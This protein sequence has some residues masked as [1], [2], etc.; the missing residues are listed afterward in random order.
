MATFASFFVAFGS[1][2]ATPPGLLD[3]DH[4]AVR[5]VMAVQQEVTADWMRRPEVLGTAIG[6]NATGAAALVVYVDRDADAAADVARSFPAN[7]RSIGVRVEL[8]E[9][10]RAMARPS[11]GVSHKAKQTPPSSSAHS[12]AGRRIW[13]MAIAAV[14]R[15]DRWSRSAGS[16]TF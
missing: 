7:L 8:T 3:N 10:F 12:A 6:L 1:T 13:R 11:T 4:A 2:A 9:K 15:S 14:A 16:S 5:A